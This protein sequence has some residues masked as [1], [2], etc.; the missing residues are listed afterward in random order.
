MIRGHVSVLFKR[1]PTSIARLRRHIAIGLIGLCCYLQAFSQE[2]PKYDTI[3]V[4]KNTALVLKDTTI[5][6]DKDTTLILPDSVFYSIQRGFYDRLRDRW[7]QRKLTKQL[8]NLLFS[9]PSDDFRLDTTQFLKSENPFLAYEGKIIGSISLTQLE[10]LGTKMDDVE[11]RPRSVVQKLGNTVN[12]KTRDRVIRNNLLFQEGDLIDPAL[13]ADNERIIRELPYIKDARIYVK[14]RSDDPEIMDIVILTKDVVALS[15]D[16][17]ARDFDSGVLR[18]DH[19]NIFGS[20]HEVD[21]RF[22]L[23]QSSEQRFSYE[24]RYRIPNIRRTFASFEFNHANT[25]NFDQTGVRLERLFITPAIKVAGGLELSQQTI[26][27]RRLENIISDLDF[28][29][30]FVTRKFDFQEAWLARAF[31]LRIRNAALRERTRLVLSG[32]VSRINFLDRPEVSAN[33]NQ[34][35]H[36]H[37]SLIAGIGLSQQRYFKDQLIF[38]YGRTEDIPY[39]MALELLGGYDYGEFNDRI[40][41]GTRLSRGGYIGNTGYFF[42]G[43]SLEGYLNRGVYEQAQFQKG[44]RFISNLIDFNRWKFR[45]FISISYTRGI[46]RFDSEFIDIRNQ[47]GIRGLESNIFRGTQRFLLQV[48]TVSFTPVDLLDFRLALFGFADFGWI[49]DGN[50]NIFKE[51]SQSGLGIGFRIRNDNLTFNAIEIRLAYYPRA[52]EGIDFVDLDLSGNSG[53]RFSDFFIS[54]PAIGRFN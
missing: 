20:G 2:K 38:G 15:F 19:R 1:G 31:P 3:R 26:R 43:I 35:F 29:E 16:I 10:A 45:Q 49:N 8:F 54:K 30:V 22:A 36:N 5:R 24:F 52:P 25:L 9:L 4:A 51:R 41:L 6:F 50:R 37:T 34:E 53:F 47:N 44:F 7:Y 12:F 48:E 28:D 27:E 13:L 18:I 14:P 46:N 42:S 40:F 17:E 11:R 21:N 33:S 39:G 32:R 23:D